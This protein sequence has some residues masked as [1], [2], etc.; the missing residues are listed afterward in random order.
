[1]LYVTGLALVTGAIVGWA[2]GGRLRFVA[3]HRIRFWWLVVLGFGLQVAA[4]RIDLGR[5]DTAIVLGG[6]VALLT[7]AALNPN[8]VGIGVV[9]V[10][11]AANAL[12]IGVNGGMPVRVQ[13]VVA[14]HIATPAQEASLN[15][16]SRHHEEGAGDKLRFLDDNIPLSPFREVVSFGDLILA[17][18]VAATVAHLFRPVLLHAQS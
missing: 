5:L 17:V 8:L 9:S 2:T 7:F 18:G 15:Y 14:A 11:V 6:A 3:H 1:M 13:A 10:G 16:G 12:V 4:D